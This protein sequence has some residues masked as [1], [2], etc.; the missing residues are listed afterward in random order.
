MRILLVCLGNICRSPTAEAALREAA[1]EAG[2]ADEVEIDSA[3]TGAWHI[4]E[5]PDPRMTAAAAEVGL[6]L[7]GAA[8]QFM[9]DDFERFDLILVMDRRNLADVLTLA[10][11]EEERAKVRLFREFEQAA[12]GD[13][14][15]DPYFGGSEGFR[16]VV[17]VARA[18]ARGVVAHLLQEARR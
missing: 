9:P 3:G 15:P 11:T 13:E 10:R 4:G 14:L 18:A 6:T 1:A 17:E 2:L 12:E 8:R 7:D 16:Q 5:P